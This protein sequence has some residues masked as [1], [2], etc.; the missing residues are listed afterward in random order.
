MHS[1][2]C[3]KKKLNKEEK[4]KERKIKNRK[5]SFL[6]RMQVQIK[7]NANPNTNALPK[8]VLVSVG[9]YFIDRLPSWH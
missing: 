6:I 2:K 7:K 9:F 1:P 3:D 8:I 4:K 5:K